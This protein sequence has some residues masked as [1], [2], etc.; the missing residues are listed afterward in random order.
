M[1]VGQGN[2]MVGNF[3]NVMGKLEMVMGIVHREELGNYFIQ[4][5]GINKENSFIPKGIEFTGQ[6]ILATKEWKEWIKCDKVDF[7]KHIKYVHEM[8]NYCYW[9]F[10]IIIH[11][12]VDF[13]LIP[14]INP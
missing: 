11:Q 13:N 3:I 8:Q 10:G 2:L 9:N 4:H 14:D 12:M 6:G 7:P 5:T 1:E